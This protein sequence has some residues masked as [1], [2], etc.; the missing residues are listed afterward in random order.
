MLINNENKCSLGK[1][2]Y[3][4][5]TSPSLFSIERKS[6]TIFFLSTLSRMLMS[7]F[8]AI[9]VIGARRLIDQ[10]FVSSP[11]ID[12]FGQSTVLVG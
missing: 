2:Y 7:N 5:I 3:M 12:C 4:R 10:I 1:T 8:A 9:T 11:S 6:T